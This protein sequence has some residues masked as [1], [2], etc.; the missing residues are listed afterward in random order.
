VRAIR[1]GIRVC[2]HAVDGELE[3][4]QPALSSRE[5]LREGERPQ[6]RQPEYTES[7][8]MREY[9]YD[10]YLRAE[11]RRQT[12][13]D[14]NSLKAV[15]QQTHEQVS[16]VKGGKS[17]EMRVAALRDAQPAARNGY[18]LAVNDR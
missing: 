6:I 16:V 9:V 2:L 3:A 17:I 7:T 13:D 11:L 12:T 10:A 5:L 15:T 18:E 1:P 4:W 8:T 14:R